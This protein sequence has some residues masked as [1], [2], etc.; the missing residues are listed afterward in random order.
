MTFTSLANPWS[1]ILDFTTTN[2]TKVLTLRRVPYQDYVDRD[3][4]AHSLGS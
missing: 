1:A 3:Y 2:L 4:G